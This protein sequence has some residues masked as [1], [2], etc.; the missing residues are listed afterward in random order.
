M[1]AETQGQGALL[2]EA[3]SQLSDASV[4]IRSV[5][6]LAEKREV[7]A[8]EDIYARSGIKLV[9]RGTRLSGGF[10]ERLVSHKL[11]RP[12]EQTIRI[13]DAPDAAQIISLAHNEAQRIPS[14]RPLLGEE[15]R[16]R[17]SGLLSG[18]S[19]PGP[20]AMKIAV[21]QEERPR[22]FQHSLLATVISMVLGVRG[23]LAPQDLRALALASLLHD[24][25]ELHID[26]AVLEPGR[27]FSTDDL[28]HIYAHPITGY[29]MLREFS[30][31]P[32]G[33]AEAVLQH[34]ERLDGAGYPNRLS[35]GR[36]SLV[37]RF[38]AVAEVTASLIE[39]HGADKRIGMKFRM[40]I[41]K[42]DPQAVT[43]I[44]RLFENTQLDIE[45]GLDEQS[46][47][48]RLRQVGQLFAGW[49]DFLQT[50][51]AS[52]LEKLERV[53]RRVDGLRM[54]VLEPG[55]DQYR[56]DDILDITGEADP[57]VCTELM[58]LLDELLWHFGALLRG[59]DRDQ[60]VW[61]LEIPARVAPAFHVWLGQVRGF[62]GN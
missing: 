17:I 28:R 56:L 9:S 53:V 25:G 51:S 21:I 32:K 45:S 16:V 40:N 18:A 29:L 19:I 10:Y 44:Y 47:I 5:T 30:E 23:N 34:H 39:N 22:L 12:I 54:M 8:S 49:D 15:M 42:Y 6:D 4:F 2:A 50:C 43:I 3:Q 7:T 11:L 20:L 35:A 60:G 27:R 48:E 13:A 58:V 52:E 59:V 55:Y 1:H 14:L 38:L 46:L 33:T 41:K 24:I 62:V 61:G 36:I 37:S 31:L 26:P 57:D